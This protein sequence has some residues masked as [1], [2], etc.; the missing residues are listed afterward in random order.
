MNHYR[1]SHFLKT[2]NTMLK[3]KDFYSCHGLTVKLCQTMYCVYCVAVLQV[4]Y[5]DTLAIV[6]LL[7]PSYQCVLFTLGPLPPSSPVLSPGGCLTSDHL[8]H[9]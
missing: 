8:K 2:I 6:S 4:H 1:Y 9:L 3:K 5:I 7:P